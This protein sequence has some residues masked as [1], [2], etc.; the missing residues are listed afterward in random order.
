MCNDEFT[1]FQSSTSSSS[2]NVSGQEKDTQVHKRRCVHD[3]REKRGVC[4]DY[5]H[6]VVAEHGQHRERVERE[7][8]ITVFPVRVSGDG[9]V[10][11]DVNVDPVM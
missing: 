1:L 8:L 9:D 3:D 5:E 10:T 7:S 11:L 2:V 4:D 6:E